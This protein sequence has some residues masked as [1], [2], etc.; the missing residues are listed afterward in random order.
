MIEYK[1]D[2]LHLINGNCLDSLSF[3]NDC[4]VDMVLTDL[5]YGTTNCKWDTIIPFK[6][7]WELINRVTKKSA[8][9]ALFGAEPFSSALRMSNI[10][11][12]K[13]DWT[14]EKSQTTGFL[15]AWKMPLRATE[16][17]SIFYREPP[18]YN[19]IL[20]DKE[21]E[22][23]R[24]VTASTKLSDCYGSHDLNIHRCPPNKSMPKDILRFN[25]AQ[26][27]IHPTQKPVDL[28]KYLITTYTNE[29]DIVLDLTMGSCSTGMAC[30]QTKREFVGCELD[31]D[32]YNAAIERIRKETR[33]LELF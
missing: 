16:N 2:N 29:G 14:W 23:I 19:P 20:R 18:T 30:K 27:N 4:S 1:I 17:I 15:N 11:N 5:P 28:L 12:Y 7:M 26:S 6:P 13:Y 32:Y 9:I 25:N 8:V 10:K 3:L 24:P 21:E 22:N 33:Q 31:E